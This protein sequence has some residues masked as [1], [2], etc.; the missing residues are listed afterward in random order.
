MWVMGSSIVVC[1]I[2]FIA[3]FIIDWEDEE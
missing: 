3:I 2:V 1:V